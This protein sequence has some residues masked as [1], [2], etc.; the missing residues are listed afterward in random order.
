M[1]NKQLSEAYRQTHII[2]DLYSL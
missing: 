2:H 1:T